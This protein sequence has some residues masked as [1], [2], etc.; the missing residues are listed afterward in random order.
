MNQSRLLR[1]VTSIVVLITAASALAYDGSPPRSRTGAPAVGS[2]PSESS[3]RG[4]HSGNAL[5]TSGDIT[6]DAPPAYYQP[7]ATYTLTV[8]LASSATSANSGRMWGFQLTAVRADDGTGVG[9]LANVSGQGT[10]VVTG[11]GSY[12]SRQ[13]VEVGSGNRSGNASPVTWQVEWTAPD[14]GVGDVTFYYC[15]VAANG[16]NGDGGDWVYTGS[17]TVPDAATPTLDT[18]WGS[19]KA[20]YR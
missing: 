11:T 7:G 14:P 16:A 19:L 13:Y 8:R 3:C 10:M 18:T 17:H 1:I 5:N 20:R 2:V 15:G 4:C 12:T 9:T 6:L